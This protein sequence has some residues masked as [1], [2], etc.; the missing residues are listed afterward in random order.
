MT[1]E[2]AEDT[3]P[4]PRHVEN[5][6]A[7]PAAP[8][9]PPAE[10]PLPFIDPHTKEHALTG[11]ELWHRASMKAIGLLAHDPAALRAWADANVG[12]FAT[13]EARYPTTVANIRAEIAEIL[14]V[15]TEQET[16]A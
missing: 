6:A 7:A 13:V 15:V 16:A 9:A 10:A 1:R 2:E 5:L 8:P 11:P 3:P 4:E 14:E 12:A